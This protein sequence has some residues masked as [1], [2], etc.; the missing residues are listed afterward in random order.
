MPVDARP[1]KAARKAAPVRKDLVWINTKQWAW[2]R[3]NLAATVAERRAKRQSLSSEWRQ[4]SDREQ[5]EA[6]ASLPRDS[7]CAEDADNLSELEEVACQMYLNTQS[8]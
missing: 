3:E 8:C 1:Q 6:F 4:M 7:G 2:K 5:E